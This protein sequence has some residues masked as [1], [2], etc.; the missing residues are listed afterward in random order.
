MFSAT[1]RSGDQVELLVDHADAQRLG[2]VRRGEGDL[3]AG[4]P[5]AARIRVV[6]TGQDLHQ[7]GLA[8]PVLAHDGV[9]LA[10]RTH[11]YTSSSAWTPGKRLLMPDISRTSCASSG[12]VRPRHGVPIVSLNVAVPSGPVCIRAR[13]LAERAE[14]KPGARRTPRGPSPCT[15]P[16][17]PT[18]R[19][20]SRCST[21]CSP[22]SSS[23]GPRRSTTAATPR[24]GPR[25]SRPC[26]PAASATRRASG[27]GTRSSTTPNATP[28]PSPATGASSRWRS[29]SAG[30]PSSEGIVA[31][32]LTDGRPL[33]LPQRGQP[34]RLS[35]TASR[36][37]QAKR[38][39][40]LITAP[41]STSAKVASMSAS[42]TSRS[43]RASRG[44]R[45]SR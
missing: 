41:R 35:R 25:W 30:R 34:R 45:P 32:R 14:D 19:R 5:D 31:E 44:S 24:S 33:P 43:T 26:T 21:P 8:R 12:F 4:H 11:R 16:A 42:A 3:R 15:R 13:I 6:G 7:G 28:T 18:R 37:A 22:S 29:T 36:T 40:A 38:T 1:E 17:Q 10:S 9:D 39:T 23:R 27:A 20:S 2:F